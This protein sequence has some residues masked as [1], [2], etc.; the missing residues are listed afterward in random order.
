MWAACLEIGH[1]VRCIRSYTSH[2]PMSHIPSM[3]LPPYF[4]IF[5]CRD[6]PPLKLHPACTR[7]PTCSCLSFH[8]THCQAV[9]QHAA[10]VYIRTCTHAAMARQ[11]QFPSQSALDCRFALGVHSLFVF[12]VARFRSSLA[13][14][15]LSDSL[16]SPNKQDAATAHLPYL[17]SLP[18]HSSSTPLSKHCTH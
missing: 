5:G 3:R 4:V 1:R 13:F 10:H 11:C 14:P 2:P 8:D 17:N 18:C 12:L 7:G 9:T 16:S 15:R 6:T